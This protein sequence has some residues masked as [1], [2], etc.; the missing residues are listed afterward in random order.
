MKEMKDKILQL[1]KDHHFVSFAQLQNCLGEESKGDL[2]MELPAGSNIFIWQGVSRAFVNAL[3][4]LESE[5]VPTPCRNAIY[6]IDGMV[7]LL[8]IART[9]PKNGYKEAHWLPVVWRLRS[10]VTA[11]KG[12]RTL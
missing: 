11:P 7:P 1:I 6:M 8:P 9:L 4:E 3:V 12:L 5:I 2:S 10:R